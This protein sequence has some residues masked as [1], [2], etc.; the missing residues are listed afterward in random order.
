M[1]PKKALFLLFLL[2]LPCL[3][4]ANSPIQEQMPDN[5]KIDGLNPSLY[6]NDVK[7]ITG[8]VSS[9]EDGK[10]KWG[11]KYDNKNVLINPKI[12][13]VLDVSD[14]VRVSELVF[15]KGINSWDY[16]DHVVVMKERHDFSDLIAKT[17]FPYSVNYDGS[18]LIIN[19]VPVFLGKGVIDLDP[20]VE[21]YNSS[22]YPVINRRTVSYP[23]VI[24]HGLPNQS[25]V[26]AFY[27]FSHD[28]DSLAIRDYSGNNRHIVSTDVGWPDINDGVAYFNDEESDSV[29]TPFD[30]GDGV[31]NF[32]IG[33]KFNLISGSNEYLWSNK[34]TKD[35]AI[36]T[37]GNALIVRLGNTT[38]IEG[39]CGV[40]NTSEGFLS[41]G[42]NYTVLIKKNNTECS[43]AID[44]V[45]IDRNNSGLDAWRDLMSSGEIYFA[46]NGNNNNYVN[47]TLSYWWLV[48]ET[49]DD[50]L[51]L[52]LSKGTAGLYSDNM[53]GEF[54]PINFTT[55]YSN[56]TL[57]VS[58]YY[59]P[60]TGLN[61][62]FQLSNGSYNTTYPGLVAFYAF[63]HDRD[64]ETDTYIKDL[65][66]ECNLTGHNT[67]YFVE[68][69]Y[70]TN[71]T[72]L[73]VE[74]G[75]YFNITNQGLNLNNNQSYTFW[76]KPHTQDNYGNIVAF[77][78]ASTNNDFK[79]DMATNI[80]SI[81]CYI[82][83]GNSITTA[84]YGG[85]ADTWY[86]VA[87]TMNDTGAAQGNVW[88]YV[89]GI[90]IANNSGDVVG[91]GNPDG[92]LQIGCWNSGATCSNISLDNLGV[93]NKT[94]I[95]PE[96]DQIYRDQL[97]LY[98]DSATSHECNNS[99]VKGSGNNM[100]ILQPTFYLY[101]DAYNITSPALYNYSVNTENILYLQYGIIDYLPTEGVITMI[102]DEVMYFNITP[103]SSVLNPHIEWYQNGTKIS[104]SDTEWNYTGHTT[105]ESMI[106]VHNFTVNLTGSNCNNSYHNWTI[107]AL[108]ITL[109]VST[110]TW[111]LNTSFSIY[112]GEHVNLSCL[113]NNYEMTEILP[114]YGTPTITVGDGV[115][116]WLPFPNPTPINSTS[117]TTAYLRCNVTNTTHFTGVQNIT[118]FEILSY[119]PNYNFTIDGSE[120]SQQI[121]TNQS[122]IVNFSLFDNNRVPYRDIEIYEDN[123]LISSGTNSLQ[124]NTSFVLPGTHY[125][126]AVWSYT[127][128]DANY[129]TINKTIALNVY[130]EPTGNNDYLIPYIML[131]GVII[132][133]FCVVCFKL[134]KSHAIV[135]L[136]LFSAGLGL[137]LLGMSIIQ[138]TAF[139]E[140]VNI[141][142]INLLDMSFY[143]LMIITIVVIGYTLIQ[144]IVL[145]Y[146]LLSGMKE[147]D[148]YDDN[149]E[150][151]FK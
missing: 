127:E 16:N 133:F 108:P 21:V 123:I 3:S 115:D 46:Q 40:L 63:D 93:Y 105:D 54:L 45:M 27:D 29:I 44:G 149:I 14:M 18:T 129:T 95:Q 15:E 120:S 59:P 90:P 67:T 143:V 135:Q 75:S 23:P 104:E 53:Y 114:G 146:S 106:G 33:F 74:K 118:Y 60:G 11:Y 88:I 119:T 6:V 96:I 116:T 35:Y 150:G 73:K 62:S 87:V 71:A 52:N 13:I 65:V 10:T 2:V 39:I 142:I 112:Y 68:G 58:G 9:F 48:N 38:D 76:Y 122:F 24:L 43:M 99:C 98:Q 144:S 72:N 126:T 47:M 5:A 107:T 56:I 81:R 80:N 103:N 7:I 124:V 138:N 92:D 25:S 132:G 137:V 82:T 83:A 85:V 50:S 42:T 37:S 41:T 34:Y 89:N 31:A 151:V 102:Y 91:A 147:K 22:V 109:N 141:N 32:T 101:S 26:Y 66:G 57:N 55:G 4:I 134:D 20:T 70:G 51:F 61:A 28:S 111:D 30:L 140:G 113:T 130:Y 84:N 86:F 12:S 145:I 100:S 8:Y 110:V 1:K 139:Y 136:L 64:G 49:L 17:G 19:L 36:F 125:Y 121:Y 128:A 79:C 117:P 148:I 77:G 69:K 131:L 97:F 78:E 94:L